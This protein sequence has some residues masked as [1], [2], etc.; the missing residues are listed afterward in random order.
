MVIVKNVFV[1]FII[2]TSCQLFL[3]SVARRHFGRIASENASYKTRKFTKERKANKTILI[4]ISLFVLFWFPSCFYYFL[5]KTCP[6]CFPV[7][8]SEVESIFNAIMKIMTFMSSCANPLVYC[9]RAREFRQAF[10][11]IMLKLNLTKSPS[12]VQMACFP[13]CPCK[14]RENSS[15]VDSIS[16]TFFT[17]FAVMEKQCGKIPRRLTHS[18]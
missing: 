10:S 8:F 13:L 5:R 2:I 1:P 4:I 3:W 11:K 12:F 16:R 14:T 9:W 15:Q 18:V 6:R 17:T 7:T